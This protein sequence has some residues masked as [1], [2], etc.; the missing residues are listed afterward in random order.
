MERDLAVF[1]CRSSDFFY[2]ELGK[3]EGV[4]VMNGR[5]TLKR[6]REYWG[7]KKGF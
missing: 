4:T 3:R 1:N 5:V 7:K 2:D 6:K